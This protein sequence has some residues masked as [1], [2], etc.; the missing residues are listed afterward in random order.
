MAV[1]DVHIRSINAFF[2]RKIIVPMD[3]AAEIIDQWNWKRVL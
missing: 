2:Y 1:I 3:V